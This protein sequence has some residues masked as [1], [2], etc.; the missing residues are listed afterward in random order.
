M[1]LESYSGPLDLLLYLVKRDE[2]DLREVSIAKLTEQYLDYLKRLQAIDMNLAGEFLVMAATLLEIKSAMLIPSPPASQ[3]GVSSEQTC[4]SASEGAETAKFEL[5]QQLLAYKRF[6]DAAS[7]LQQRADRLSLCY[8]RKPWQ[9][10]PKTE[11]ELLAQAFGESGV[12]LTDQDRQSVEAMLDNAP[13]ADLELD[14]LHIMDLLET[15]IRLMESVGQNAAGHNVVYDDTPIGLYA[16]DIL[17]RLTRQ[18][19]WTLSE[20]LTGTNRSQAIGLFLATLELVRQ[21][22]VCVHERSDSCDGIVI[23][24][25]EDQDPVSSETQATDPNRWIDPA[26]GQMMYDWPTEEGRRAALRR[27]KLR[28][29]LAAKKQAGSPGGSDVDPGSELQE[30]DSLAEIEEEELSADDDP[31]MDAPVS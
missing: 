8:P 18:P 7:E 22:K 6:K 30:E 14:D 23:E 11:E 27:A 16:Q 5:I 26:T 20:L 17:D 4:G 24:A 28:A 25:R 1:E 9:P 15:F 31:S 13:S 19:K 2:V 12:P 3:D 10:K 29:T 21:R